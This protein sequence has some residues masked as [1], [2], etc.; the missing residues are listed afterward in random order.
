[1]KPYHLL[2]S[3]EWKDLWLY[4]N[5]CRNNR[6]NIILAQ[7]TFPLDS[8][9]PIDCCIILMSLNSKQNQNLGIASAVV[10]TVYWYQRNHLLKRK[11]HLHCA[12]TNEIKYKCVSCTKVKH[13]IYSSPLPAG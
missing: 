6:D 4:V 10:A 1:M 8:I 11:E 13:K 3:G 2:R 7:L 9:R 5:G 12:L